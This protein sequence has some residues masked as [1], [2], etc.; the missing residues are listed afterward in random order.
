MDVL[1]LLLNSTPAKLPEKDYKIKRLSKECGGDVIFRLRALP[2]SRVAEVRRVDPE[3]QQL[4]IILAGVIAPDLRNAA[5]LEKYG[6]A[7]PVD[8]LKEMLL[9]GEIDDLAIRIEQ[10]SGYKSVVVEEIKKNSGKT[11]SSN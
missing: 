3:N 2:Y 10:L 8:M 6:G 5:L 9:P 11:Q 1:E 4:H 7:T